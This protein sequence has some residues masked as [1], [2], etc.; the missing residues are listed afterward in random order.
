VHLHAQLV[1]SHICQTEQKIICMSC[2][3][4]KIVTS[5]VR[6]RYGTPMNEPCHTCGRV[7]SHMWTSHVT[8]NTPGGPGKRDS[9]FRQ[10]TATHCNTCNTH[11]NTLQHTATQYETLQYNITHNNTLQQTATCCNIHCNTLQRT[12]IH[13]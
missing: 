2:H 4:C 5:H 9:S 12:A 3:T 8:H 13:T 10:H 6:M 11:C 7:M 1:M